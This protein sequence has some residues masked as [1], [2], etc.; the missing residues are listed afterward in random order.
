[1]IGYPQGGRCK[2]MEE[3]NDGDNAWV[4]DGQHVNRRCP[5]A[6]F[7]MILQYDTDHGVTALGNVNFE[8]R[9]RRVRTLSSAG[10]LSTDK[11]YSTNPAE[12]IIDYL[13]ENISGARLPDYRINLPSFLRLK[14]FC[15]EQA[16]Y[17]DLQETIRQGTRY[18]CNGVINTNS[19]LD[20]N[21]EELL[22][23]CQSSLSYTL[24]EFDV[25]TNKQKDTTHTFTSDNI[26]GNINVKNQGFN[27]LNNEVIMHFSSKKNNWQEDQVDAVA[28][29]S[30]RNANEPDLPVELP[31]VFTNNS[32]E[33]QRLAHIALNQWRQNLL[34]VFN[35]FISALDV[36]AGDVVEITHAE[37]G[38]SSKKFRVTQ[39]EETPSGPDSPLGLRITAL[40][41]ADEVYTIN[42]PHEVDVALNTN[43]PDPTVGVTISN[44]QTVSN[45]TRT[46]SEGLLGNKRGC[47]LELFTTK[48]CC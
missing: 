44:I 16:D 47:I 35:T 43:L 28:P 20:T 19:N 1:M 7:V 22:V 14:N 3:F 31:L 10:V 29:D 25:I 26:V 9:G 23:C 6:Y 12:C 4:N 38:L 40:E 17:T 30:V 15:N 21:I 13:T 32:I 42:A 27:S 5:F 48:I 2:E 11:T 36:Q 39:V 41:Y 34:V 37:S 33:A 8:V 45:N 18:T 24:G 46:A